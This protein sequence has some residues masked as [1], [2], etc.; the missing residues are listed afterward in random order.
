MEKRT[1]NAPL[2]YTGMDVEVARIYSTEFCF[3]LTL[4]YVRFQ[5]VEIA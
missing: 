1:K 2:G 5:Q 3:E 4:M